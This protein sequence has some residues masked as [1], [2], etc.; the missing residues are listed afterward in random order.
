ML[1]P[2]TA[3]PSEQSKHNKACWECWYGDVDGQVKTCTHS[4]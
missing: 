2:V 1:T 3:I 4:A